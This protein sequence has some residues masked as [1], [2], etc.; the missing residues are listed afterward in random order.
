[1]EL[2]V[3]VSDASLDDV[4]DLAVDFMDET[5]TATTLG[6]VI[7]RAL[8]DR[9]IQ[10]PRWEALAAR[11]MV[12]YLDRAVPAVI[13]GIVAGEVTRQLESRAQD[14]MTRG[15]PSTRAEAIVATEVTTQLRAQFAPVVERALTGLQ[16]D[17]AAAAGEAVAAFREGTA[18]G[19]YKR[20]R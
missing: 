12:N 8:V 1:M 6:D 3:Q 11:A 7:V 14:A 20:R 4:V 2:K 13:E 16:Q 17:L 10:D 18:T 19:R 9:L 15:E 5:V